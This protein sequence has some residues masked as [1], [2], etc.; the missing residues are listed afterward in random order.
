MKYLYTFVSREKES[1]LLESDTLWTQGEFDRVW[2]E[3]RDAV[4]ARY[5]ADGVARLASGT[6]LY[7]SV[8]SD[9]VLRG[10]FSRPRV[11]ATIQEP[12]R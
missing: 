9:M 11:E 3:S 12:S 8:I 10:H 1:V 6:P 4:V 2:V 7:T 5:A